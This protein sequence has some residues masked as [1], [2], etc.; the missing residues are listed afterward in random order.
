MLRG[1]TDLAASILLYT[2]QTTWKENARWITEAQYQLFPGV[3]DQ[4]F[5]S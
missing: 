4:L 2:L 1:T 3:F 5:A